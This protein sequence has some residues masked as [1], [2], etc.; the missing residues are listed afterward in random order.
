MKGLPRQVVWIAA[1][2]L[3]CAAGAGGCARAGSDARDARDRRLRRALEA[4]AAQDIDRAIALCEQAL[5]RKPDLALAHRELGLMLDN[6]RGDYAG[7]LYHYRRYLELRPG[8]PQRAAVEELIRH[9]RVSFAAQ[10]AESPAELK[11]DLQARDARIRQLELEVAAWREQ[12]G[13]AAAP[14]AL[15]PAVPLPP[16]KTEP[17]AVP[18]P[19]A[20][21]AVRTHVVQPGETLATISARYYGTPAR[22]QTLFDANRDTLAN[23]NNLRV[24]ARLTIPAE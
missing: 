11:R 2:A 13:P 10:V 23:A 4:K 16:A 14:P 7:A 20:A 8:S 12:A 3:L 21:A 9:C 19:P 18:P 6:Y 5:A 24:G 15:T 22:W 1:L 17:A